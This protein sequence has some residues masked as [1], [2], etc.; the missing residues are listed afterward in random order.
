VRLPPRKDEIYHA[1]EKHRQNPAIIPH[2]QHIF[3]AIALA[4]EAETI[5]GQ[6]AKKVVDSAKRL[7]NMPGANVNAEA[8]VGQLSPEGQQAVK[9][10][11]S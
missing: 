9:S 2:A 1:N 3:Q 8:V 11:F 6:T 5:Q 4:L 7:I 10:Y